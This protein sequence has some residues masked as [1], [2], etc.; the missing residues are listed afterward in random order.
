MRGAGA[1]A[2]A[3]SSARDRRPA[4]TPDALPRPLHRRYGC[5]WPNARVAR[6]RPPPRCAA[7]RS[8]AGGPARTGRP[9]AARWTTA[10]ARPAPLRP[11]AAPGR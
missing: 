10:R 6:A 7:A 3:A 2:I 9:A 8:I 1:P 5:G 11:P 4:A